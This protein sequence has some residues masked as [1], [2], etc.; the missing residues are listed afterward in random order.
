MADTEK[1]EIRGLEETAAFFEISVPT[2]K[3]MIGQEGFPIVEKGGNGKAYKLDLIAVDAWLK[4]REEEQEKLD[5]E[6]AAKDA[7]LKLELLG[8]DQLP[9][10]GG[11]G[12]L[13]A[14]QR[15]AALKAEIAKINLA[16]LRRSLVPADEMQ[17]KIMEMFKEIRDRMRLLPDDM[18]RDV[19]LGEDDAAAMLT[20]IDEFLNDLADRYE[21]MIEEEDSAAA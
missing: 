7:Q 3:K 14:A 18:A 6:R 17:F 11:E 10:P 12:H 15:E 8:K 4:N 9:D 21:K 5:A 2:L 16:K 20:M 13:T 19:G 1:A